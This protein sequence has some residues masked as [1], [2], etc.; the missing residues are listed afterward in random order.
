VLGSAQV[1]IEVAGEVWVLSG[2]YRVESDPTCE[3]FEPVR[4]HTFVTE[5]TFGLPV[6]RW[7]PSSEVFAAINAWWQ[8]NAQ[9]GRASVLF[10]YALGKAQRILAGIDASI[11]PIICHGA[12]E[13]LNRAYRHSGVPLPATLTVG[14]VDDT[15]EF[16]R[17]LVLAPPSAAGHAWLRRFPDPSQAFASGWMLLRGAR[18]RRAVDRG[19][20]LSDHADWPG[21][22]RAIRDTGG[23]Q[24][25][26]AA[27]FDVAN[28]VMP[29]TDAAC[30]D[31]PDPS[32]CAMRAFSDLFIDLD[33]SM[34]TRRK[35]TALVDHLRRMPTGDAAWATYFLA[36][37]RPRGILSTRVLREAVLATTGLP[38]WLFEESYQA[39]GD[40][41]ETI[42]HLLPP[43]SLTDESGLG[44]WL[45]DRLLPMRGLPPSALQQRLHDHWARLDWPGRFVMNKLLT[46]GLRVGVSRQLVT[47]AVA[48]A[49]TLDEKVVAQRMIGYTD[50]LLDADPGAAHDILVRRFRAVTAALA[51]A[52]SDGAGAPDDERIGHPYP[53]FLAQPLRQSPDALGERAQWLIEWKWDGIRG[54]L[55]RRSGRAWLWS[56]GEEPIADRFPEIASTASALPDGLVLDGEVLAW[57]AQAERPLPFAVLQQRIG[58]R[59][60]TPRVL[61]EV[62]AVFVAYDLLEAEGR[63]LRPLPQR[64]RRD[65]L[66]ALLERI[67]ACAL[68]LSPRVSEDEAADWPALAELRRQA[69]SRG[70]EGFMLKRLDAAYGMG[71]SRASALGEWWKWKIDPLTVDAVL[72]YAQRGHGRRAS[73]YTDY[74]FAVWDGLPG[75]SRRLMPFAKAYSGL[76]DEE[77]VR[78]D[79][80]VRRTTVE[81]FGPVRSVT[82]TL[83][84]EL[85]FEGIQHSP[86]HKSGIAVR[87]PRMLRWRQDK[88]VEEADTLDALRALLRG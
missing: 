86:R 84:F 65:R 43:P 73:L 5:S 85:G 6:Y 9:A 72:V 47:R 56:R 40:L 12:V 46:G 88:P 83:V 18:R 25:I 74:T 33:A 68:R 19:F 15:R 64:E 81:K 54:Q 36:G 30:V 4:C 20:V 63:D 77:I 48:Q 45:R 32:G 62:P 66:E 70:V 75:A 60:L 2:D 76:T 50:G 79:T 1:R 61:S 14:K 22:Q 21:L 11:G 34:S 24:S 69:R 82:P 3:A 37:G 35:V 41:A 38:H 42:A 59:R 16:A 31:A 27:N 87:F 51:E 55:V 67:P 26:G 78:V 52:S 8:T 7:A 71:R 13:P 58:R 57:D 39:V 10:A 17:A 44:D 28:I 53:F 29:I 49:F 23:A 80:I